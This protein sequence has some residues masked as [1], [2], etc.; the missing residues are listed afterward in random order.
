[1]PEWIHIVVQSVVGL[2]VLF[3]FTRF[4]GK[5]QLTQLSFFEYIIGITIGNLA[6]FTSV[7][8]EGHWLMGLIALAVWVVIS[9]CIEVLQMRSK[10]A[11]DIIDS[12]STFLIKDGKILEGNLK[13]EKLSNEELLT[14][15]RKKSVFNVEEIDHAVMEPSGELNVMLKDQYKPITLSQLQKGTGSGGIVYEIV[16]D[17]KIMNESLTA[18]GFSTRWLNRKLQEM[19]AKLEDVYFAQLD[20]S[21]KLYVDLYEDNLN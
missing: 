11:R 7:D 18:A 16:L 8:L 14:L 3:T 9:L 13:K 6:G 12:R 1:M 15:L 19:G 4:L 20:Q 10:K 2:A 17:G 21:G 5:R